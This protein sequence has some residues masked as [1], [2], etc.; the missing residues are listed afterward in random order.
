MNVVTFIHIAT[1]IMHSSIKH[2]HT[3]DTSHCNSF[4]Y[5]R[6]IKPLECHKCTTTYNYSSYGYILLLKLL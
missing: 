1:V 3:V 4:S 2:I 5:A 6:L